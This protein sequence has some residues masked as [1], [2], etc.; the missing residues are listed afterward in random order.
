MPATAVSPQSITRQFNLDS[1]FSFFRERKKK[2]AVKRKKA[3]HTAKEETPFLRF[4]SE[5]RRF[6]LPTG[7]AG[8]IPECRKVG[9]AVIEHRRD[10]EDKVQRKAQIR[11]PFPFPLQCLAW[12]ERCGCRFTLLQR[13]ARIANACKSAPRHCENAW[14]RRELLRC[15][16]R[17]FWV[18]FL[19]CAMPHSGNAG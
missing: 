16:Q 8:L 4:A 14:R 3:S 10:I 15:P 9:I 2:S 5:K 6:I 13:S 12:K 17:S 1:R 7:T 11:F 18:N 19:C